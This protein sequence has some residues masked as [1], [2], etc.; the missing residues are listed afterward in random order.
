M[1]DTARP[2]SDRRAADGPPLLDP[3]LLGR[4][5]RLQLHTRR[6]LA[7]RFVGDHRSRRHGTS[8][9][10][11]DQREYT[12]GDD[13]RLIDPHLLARLD[14]LAIRLYEAEDDLHVRLLVDTSA[15]MDG[16]KLRTAA[17]LAGALGFVSLIRRDVVT[18]HTAPP[19]R[20]PRRFVGRNAA[21]PMLDHLGALTAGGVTDLSPAVGDLLGRSPSAGLTVVCSDLFTP[22]WVS[23]LRRLP[24]RG[25]EVLVVHVLADDDLRPAI[26]GD[27]DLVDAETGER[28]AV[29]LDPVAL[30]A[31]GV[32]A[33][34]WA[35][36]VAAQ[37][38]STGATYVR[39]P[40]GADVG[41]LL[42]RAWRDAGVLR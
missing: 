23:V 28:V 41:D 8:L 39:V 18:V 31:Y 19:G 1:S 25:S 6:R 26:V 35:D 13:V 17:Q 12:P 33:D 20:A 21:G 42:L 2:G 4:L 34:A 15:S 24:A 38:R 11:A 7:G 14:L 9:D 22:D 29:S 36:D 32:L 27:V 16:A 10:F 40:A 3:A 37:A 30:D 5:E